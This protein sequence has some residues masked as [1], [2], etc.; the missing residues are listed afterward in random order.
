MTDSP[1]TFYSEF[2]VLN[3]GTEIPQTFTAWC[4][5]SA[6]ASVLGR[7]LW[8]DMG[9]FKVF[10]NMYVIL[11]AGSGQMRKSTAI[12]VPRNLLELVSPPPNLISQK[13]TPEAL[14]DAL[15]ISNPDP[16][17]I[18]TG[19][20][21]GQGFVITDELTNFLNRSSNDGGIVPMLI[22]FYD[23]RDRFS[24]RTKGRGLE[25]LTSTCLGMLAATTPEELRKAIPEEVIGSGLASRILFVYEDTPSPPVAFPTYSRR[26][27]EAKE[28]CVRLLQRASALG[29][30]IKLSDES[31]A[32]CET[33]YNE[34]C[35][36]S[37]LLE[38]PHLRGY[39]SRRYIHILKLAISLTV[40]LTETIDITP[41]ILTKA[42]QLIAWNEVHLQRVVQLVTMNEKG[43]VISTVL[44]TI[45]RHKQIERADLLKLLNHRLD[46][47]ELT[48]VLE[49][50]IKS[51]QVIVEARG[52]K[53][54]YFLK[55]TK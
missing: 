12:N 39:A 55:E 27:L 41:T 14:I 33:C 37:R 44:T 16:K 32:W 13:I 8:I 21:T 42:E 35:Y 17:R 22:E 19:D 47:R 24:Y 25:V 52:A 49:T 3:S 45:A 50:L 29:G 28:F 40:G 43:G 1:K 7:R 15:K 4:S 51:N 46:S 10:P 20:P 48:D 6:I 38:D 5:L 53:I 9:P 54:F 30:Q 34:R 31:R 23:C 36:G 26:Q 2:M 18:S 11:I